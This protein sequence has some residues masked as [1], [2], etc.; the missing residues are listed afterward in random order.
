MWL[1]LN[2]FVLPTL[3]D[4]IRLCKTGAKSTNLAKIHGAITIR[5]PDDN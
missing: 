1:M 5:R 4:T 2:S 3:F